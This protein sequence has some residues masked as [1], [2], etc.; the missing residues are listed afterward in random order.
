MPTSSAESQNT[1]ED[2]VVQFNSSHGMAGSF[3]QFIGKVKV[4]ATSEFP[5]YCFTTS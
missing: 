4:V 2:Q 3:S 1:N 5:S